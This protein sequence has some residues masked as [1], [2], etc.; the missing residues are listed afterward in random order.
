MGQVLKESAKNDK[1][2]YMNKVKEFIKEKNLIQNGDHIIIGVSGGADSVYLLLILNELRESMNLTIT[3]VH[4]NHMI[5][6]EAVDDQKFVQDLCGQLSI[7]CKI[8]EI[9]VKQIAKREKMSLE[10]AGRKARYDAFAKTM[11][12][13]NADKIAIAHHQ[14]DQAETFLYR[15]VRGTGIYGAG[16]MREKDGNLIRPLL[17]VKKEEI[18][19]YLKEAGQAWVEDA[20]NQDDAFARNQIRNQVIP[21][22]EMINEQAVEHIGWLCEDI[23]EVTTYLTD[24]IEESFLRCTK[25]IGQGFEINCDQ[26]LLENHWIQKQVLKKVLEETAGKKKDLE[27]RHIEDLLTLVENGTGK[28]IS[29]PY[30]MVAEKNYQY[31]K[32]QKGNISDKQEMTGKILCEEVTDLTNI[33]EN[34]CIKIIDYD[35]I[36]TGVQLRCRKPGDFFTFGK[37]Q[38]RKSLSRYFIDEKIPRQLREEIPLVADGSHIVWIVGR[39]ISEYYKIKE[40]TK[41]YLKL[42]FKREGDDSNG[43]YQSNDFRGRC[44]QTNRGD[45]SADQ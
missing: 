25:P 11:K 39:R 40:S 5:R 12:K 32:V 10:E 41:R 31:I 14:N 22:L 20:S 15:V 7:P 17:C 1:V 29:L 34:D 4:I 36:E 35:R 24:Q 2:N 16:A 19:K 28:R 3:A 26:L 18:V 27:R 9:D 33:V 30:N 44:K 37:D 6:R 8:F 38:K 23:K 45:G 42:E 21:R 13:Y 43:E